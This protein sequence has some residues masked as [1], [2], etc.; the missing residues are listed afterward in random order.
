MLGAGRRVA[1]MPLPSIE[2][3]MIVKDGGAS[4]DRCLRSVAGL[5]DRI[6]VGDTGSTDD[7]IAIARR[8][9]A[10]VFSIPWVDDFAAARNRVLEAA[11]CDW[12]LVLDA[13]EMLDLGE[14]A[15]QLPALLREKEFHAYTLPR[16]DYVD[17]LYGKQ[18]TQQAQVNPGSLAETRAYPG[19]RV[20]F[21]TRLF[22]RNPGVFF[23][24][25][26]HEQVTDQ[27]DLLGLARKTASLTIHHLGYVET[28]DAAKEEKIRFYHQLGSRKALDEPANFEANLQLGIAELFQLGRP[29]EALTFL[30][31]AVE[32]RPQD[33]RAPLYVGI[34]MLRLGRLAL[35]K[36]SLVRA[37]ALGERGAILCDALGDCFLRLGEYEGALA[38]Y[39]EAQECGNA[40]PIAD[41]KLGAA[42]VH[43]GHAETGLERIRGALRRAP[44][45][46]EIAELLKI[47]ERVLASA[48]PACPTGMAA[49]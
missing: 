47:S 44:E 19:Y 5:V 45:A 22:R 25:C 4:L 39:R 21:H 43:A 9:G 38:A 31:R 36:V 10:E 34:C 11:R 23:R 41:A 32:V 13:D 28:P 29:A 6:V 15:E 20:S 3:S 48:V 27:I 26:V 14:A 1:Y 33:G 30:L 16:W 8:H 2:L 7:S 46:I 49:C 35:A 12:V 40:S 17:Q 42:E 24:E 37:Y 18:A